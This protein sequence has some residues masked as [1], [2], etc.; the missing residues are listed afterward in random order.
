M[1]GDV[2][3]PTERAAL[4][5]IRRHA[6]MLADLLADEAERAWGRYPTLAASYWRA[7]G[8]L[9]RVA[10]ERA[11]E[12]EHSDA[13]G[14]PASVHYRAIAAMRETLAA[15]AIAFADAQRAGRQEG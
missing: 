12:E 7:A 3:T 10:A 5:H 6:A 14:P 15:E 9:L 1:N 8:A 2:M 13:G 11:A 4:D